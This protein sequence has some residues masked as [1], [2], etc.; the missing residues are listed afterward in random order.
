VRR[1]PQSSWETESL[2]QACVA[3]AEAKRK[4]GERQAAPVRRPQ[5]RRRP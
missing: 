1:V 2:W 3:Q 4:A 5:G